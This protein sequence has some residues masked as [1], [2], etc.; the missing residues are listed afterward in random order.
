MRIGGRHDDAMPSAMTKPIGEHHQ[1]LAAKIVEVI[2][3]I[4]DALER[5][6]FL[7]AIELHN[8]RL[9]AGALV[10]ERVVEAVGDDDGVYG[11]KRGCSVAAPSVTRPE[12]LLLELKAF[13]LDGRSDWSVERMGADQILSMRS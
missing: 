10:V 6:E 9:D 12:E 11:R 1:L 2:E 5:A 13:V 7:D 4:D 8:K 3:D